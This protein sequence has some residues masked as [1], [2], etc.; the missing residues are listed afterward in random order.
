MWEKFGEGYT[1]IIYKRPSV[2]SGQ[3]VVAEVRTSNGKVY[4]VREETF[5]DNEKE[6][7]RRAK[8]VYHGKAEYERALYWELKQEIRPK[9]TNDRWVVCWECGRKVP[10]GQAV[11]D[12]FGWYCGC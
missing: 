1:L 9:R 4:Y 10:P 2:R 11:H 6:L 8:K 7:K 5:R 3:K 12:G